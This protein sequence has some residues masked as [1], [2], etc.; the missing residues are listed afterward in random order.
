MEKI[1]RNPVIG[2]PAE[3]NPFHNGHALH[4]ARA[5]KLLQNQGD[6][7]V[8]LSSSFTQRGLPALAD[9][10]TRA[11]MALANGADLVLELPFPY[12]CNAA[13]EFA[14]GA[15]DT[16]AALGFVTHLSFGIE[17]FETFET[18]E[19]LEASEVFAG[20]GT[21]KSAAPADA[22]LP[23]LI[24]AINAIANILIHES[25]AFKLELKK[26]LSEGKSY[27]R[28]IAETLDSIIPGGGAFVSMPNNALAISYLLRVSEKNFAMKILPVLREGSGHRDGTAGA[29]AS[30][31]AIRSALASHMRDD[32]WDD[33]WGSSWI[34]EAMPPSA[35][36]LLKGELQRGRL[37]TQTGKL[38]TLLQGFLER[39]SPEDL[40]ECAGITEGL[41][42]LFLKR[43]REASSYED[44]I[45]RCVC[46]RYTRN[47]L[48]RQA[49]RCL[50]G[51]DR[52]TTLTLSRAEPP[53]IRVLGY[54]RR[55]QDLLHARRR[56][57]HAA[58]PAITR[59]AEAANPTARA[60]AELEFRASRFREMLLPHPDLK[61]EERQ[62]P[63]RFFC[64]G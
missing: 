4:I 46:A 5:R 55:G 38:W 53:Y 21:E 7:V 64:E 1:S 32:S 50:V 30:A 39:S 25:C 42:N 23:R 58:I 17:A 27:P 37:W 52:W 24:S 6:V 18:F 19:S 3:Y 36:A 57:S 12:A 48:Q 20:F 59:L 61:H 10:W 47:R 28:S 63:A 11:S 54:N 9:K 60:L 29:L 33:F 40:R 43:Y 31:A 2:I 62:K 51:I 35:L 34:R 15:V 22:D 14:R 16:L 13:P 44:F 45:G 8:V 56:S 49:A 26:K 41:E